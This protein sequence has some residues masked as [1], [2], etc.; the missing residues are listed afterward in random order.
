[1]FALGVTH[2]ADAAVGHL[3]TLSKVVMLTIIDKEGIMST[4]TDLAPADRAVMRIVAGVTAAVT[5]ASLGFGA[6]RTAA[7]VDGSAV[8]PVI[9][10][11][12]VPG[13]GVPAEIATAEVSAAAI[14]ETARA[15]LVASTL[16]EVITGAVVAVAIIAVLLR[17]ASGD[18]FHR[19][20]V[21][22]GI[23][24]GFALLIG[25]LLGPGL[26]GL[27]QLYASSSLNGDG[28]GPFP[29][30]FTFDPGPVGLAFVVLALA[31]VFRAGTRLQRETEGLV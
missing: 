25:G 7:L 26:R 1:M 20:L 29:A 22:V 11:G 14:G 10:T 17:V 8:V 4:T 21:R 30:A 27:G 13:S 16:I 6:A 15:L 23:V 3:R 31:M 19:S 28:D 18:P 12:T 9:A 5:V 24:A 2:D